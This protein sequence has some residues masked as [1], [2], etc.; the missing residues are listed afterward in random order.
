[1]SV[2]KDSTKIFPKNIMNLDLPIAEIKSVASLWNAK[3]KGRILGTNHEF[4]SV[5]I[6]NWSAI[7]RLTPVHHRDLK[8]VEGEIKFLHYLQGKAP[9]VK[10]IKSLEN[11]LSVQLQINGQQ[12]IA[13]VF[14]MIGGISL[15][16]DETRDAGLI[17]LWGETM[18]SLHKLSKQYNTEGQYYRTLDGKT[19]L[20]LAEVLQIKELNVIELVKKKWAQIQSWP[21]P[22]SEWGIIHG[23]LTMSNIHLLDNQLYVFDFDN[24]M[25]APYLYD[26]A[27]TF[28]ITL[29]SLANEKDYHK[30]AEYFIQ[31]FIEGYK[32]QCSTTIDADLLKLLMELY[33]LFF[34][35][36][37]SQDN[38]HPYR[39]YV[40]NNMENG[41][42][43]GFDLQ[44]LVD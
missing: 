32:R 43:T 31:N 1:M 19:L 41:V 9:V 38:K 24:C 16:K 23:D 4:Y 15:C 39:E 25:R 26:I 34:Y 35:F 12:L 2:K 40:L 42:L 30:R 22:K 44:K 8:S 21:L 3:L 20:D 18:G 29:L 7:L 6:G 17:Q 37:L 33:N 36:L 11:K 27:I 5:T 28:H 14:E 10:V 13:C